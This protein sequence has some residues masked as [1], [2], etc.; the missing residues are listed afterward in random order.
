MRFGTARCRALGFRCS[1]LLDATPTLVV[2]GRTDAYCSPEAA[3]ALHDRLPGAR[4]LVWFDTINH[5]DL[6]DRPLFV[7]PAVARVA[8]WMRTHLVR[9]PA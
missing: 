3:Q 6:Y 4:K 2:H 1:D 7:E 5:I 8:D 9:V